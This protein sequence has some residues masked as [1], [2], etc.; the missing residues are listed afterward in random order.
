[1][2][3]GPTED[4]KIGWRSKTSSTKETN[5][6]GLVYKVLTDLYTKENLYGKKVLA[7]INSWGLRSDKNEFWSNGRLQDWT[8]KQNIQHE[9]DKKLWD[10]ATN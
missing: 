1:M 3:F 4:C 9:R 7:S 2:N 10:H 6:N 5:T 8:E